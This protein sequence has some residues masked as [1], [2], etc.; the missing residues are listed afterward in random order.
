MPQWHKHLLLSEQQG[1][2][3]SVTPTGVRALKR[4][5]ARLHTNQALIIII[6]KEGLKVGFQFQFLL[7]EDGLLHQIFLASRAN[8][9]VSFART[10]V[11]H[12]L[13]GK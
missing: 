4:F 3:L 1:T 6:I 2:Q 8:R 7:Q 12:S 13:R 9:L 10:A 5:V 11:T